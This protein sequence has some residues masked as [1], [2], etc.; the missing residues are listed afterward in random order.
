MGDAREM[1]PRRPWAPAADDL[2]PGSQ[3]DLQL[4][5]GIKASLSGPLARTA[6]PAG[7]RRARAHARR[8][9]AHRPW[10]CLARSVA[11]PAG[12]PAIGRSS[13]EPVAPGRGRLGP[14]QG[15]RGAVQPIGRAPGE[16]PHVD[17]RERCPAPFP[18]PRSRN[19]RPSLKRGLPPLRPLLRDEVAFARLV[20]RPRSAPTPTNRNEARRVA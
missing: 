7:K 1:A 18:W 12:R 10:P 16:L 4:H 14:L 11:P 17:G 20:F 15:C 9:P 5:R 2:A 6:S 8:A 3:D 13:P 19:H